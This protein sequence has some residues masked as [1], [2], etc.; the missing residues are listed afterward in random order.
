MPPEREILISALVSTYGAGRFMR[1]LLEDLEAQTIRDQMEIVIVDSASPDDEGDIVREFQQHF[2]NI[3]YQRT[4]ERENAHVSVNRAFALSRG[5]YVSPAATDDRHHPLAFERMVAELEDYP[6]V[7]LVYADSAVTQTE[8]ETLADAHRTAHFLWPEFDPR[9]LFDVCYIG[10]H[11]VY[12]RTM[13]EKYGG[14]DEA[15][16]VA[17][18]YEFWLRLV[19]AGE[20]FR[21]IPEVL[22]LYLQNPRGNEYGNPQLCDEESELAR[23]RYW[24]NEWG[25]RPRPGTCF[26]FPVAE[27]APRATELD[28]ASFETSVDTTSVDGEIPSKPRVTEIGDD[29]V[30]SVIMPTRNRPGWLRRA[31]SSV[32]AQSLTDLELIVVNDAGETVDS[33]LS[34]LD[35]RGCIQSIRFAQNRERSNAR[36]AGLALARGKYIAYLDD[37]DWWEPD[38]LASLVEELERTNAIGVYSDARTVVEAIPDGDPDGPYETTQSEELCLPDF[39]R[40]SLLVG[41]F[42]PTPCLL[43]RRDALETAGV[44]DPS[45]RTHEDWDLWIRLTAEQ[46]FLHLRRAS[47]NISWRNDGSSTTSS[48]REDFPITAEKIHRRYATEAKSRPGVPE[49]QERYVAGLRARLPRAPE[50]PAASTQAN[51]PS[52]PAETHAAE[53]RLAITQGN[54]REANEALSRLFALAPE[55]PE[56]WLLRGVLTI[57]HL[58]YGAAADAFA[59]ALRYGADERRAELGIAMAALG[60]GQNERAWNLLRALTDEHPS[61]GEIV[62]W[63]LRAACVRENFRDAIPPVER[64]LEARPDDSSVRFALAGLFI[65]LGHLDAAVTEHDR[66]LAKEPTFDGLPELAAALTEAGAR[67]SLAQEQAG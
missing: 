26:L 28:K 12:R 64:Y 60:R 44:F 37:D 24:Q 32:M 22:S 3:V 39:D 43:H 2:D 4:P 49:A 15:M 30:V 7:G 36:N 52:D 11:P 18:D 59:T 35:T 38:H 34:N 25:P 66:I 58:D 61:D 23:L 55:H 6:E 67:L 47:A 40:S 17:G 21:H 9:L 8:N 16:T 45:L 19:A 53:A 46:P 41:N 50:E 42:V 51:A 27:A 10:P 29:P 33:I 31:V 48:S 56:G 65:R 14:F 54:L 63:L 13:H 5:K 20:Q 57:Q 62:H 1:Q